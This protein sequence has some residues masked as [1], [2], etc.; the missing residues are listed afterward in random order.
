VTSPAHRAATGFLRGALIALAAQVVA[1]AMASV[2]AGFPAGAAFAA[3]VRIVVPLA[4]MALAGAVGAEAL[5]VG[6]RGILTFAVGGLAAGVVLL[7][8]APNLAGLTGHENPAVVLPYAVAT[9]A[10]A[11]ASLG[12]IGASGLSAE[13]GFPC[14]RAE[15]SLGSAVAFGGGG[16][17]G[18]LVGVIPFLAARAGVNWP[19]LASQFIWLASSIGALAVPLCLGGAALARTSDRR[20]T[21]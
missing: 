10:V 4:G 14:S 5:V 18:G 8:A 1:P 6:R 9:S 15:C 19:D 13:D 16:A 21:R 3:A 20:S 11:F 12:T 17:I 2:C 7:V